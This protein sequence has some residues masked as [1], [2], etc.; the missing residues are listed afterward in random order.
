MKFKHTILALIGF[1][2]YSCT[3]GFDRDN[4]NPNN[5]EIVPTYGIYNNATKNL[6]GI[7][8]RGSFGSARMTL[9]WVQYSASFQYNEESRYEYRRETPESIFNN[10]YQ[11]ANN[12]KKII[13]NVTDPKLKDITATYGDN[14]VQIAA[15]RILIVYTF[16]QLVDMFGDIPY[17]SYGSTNP[18]F[19][20]LD[21]N[22][23]TPKYAKQEDIYA[24]LLIELVEAVDILDNTSETRIFY[25]TQTYIGDNLFKNDVEKLKRFAN[26]LRLRIA[27]RLKN[28]SLSALAA[29]HIDE[30]KADPSLLMQSNDDSV[31]VTYE[32][33]SIN[34]A[35]QYSAFFVDNRTDYTISKTFIDL[36]KGQLANSGLT[37]PDPRLQKVAAPKGVSKSKSLGKEYTETT[38]L[39]Q[40]EG[41]PFGLPNA[42][43]ARQRG[44]NFAN[45]SFY[46]YNL[47]RPDYT[48]YLMEYA[49]V[50]FLLAEANN[51]DQTN[52]EAG[53]KASM[54]KWGVASGDITN[55]VA[56][57]PTANQENVLNQKYIAL[58]MQPYE[59]WSEYRRTG[60]PKFLI[61]PGDPINLITTLTEDS[62]GLTTIFQITAT[63]RSINGNMTDLPAR[64]RYP[65]TEPT[66]NGKN[67]KE[68]VSRLGGDTMQ[69]KL[70]WDN[71]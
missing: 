30:L 33:N 32:N 23:L 36:L 58:F 49:E 61:K 10:Y 20:A 71:N 19:Q 18:D 56:T 24:D 1:S 8:S 17:W 43:G 64:I 53:V 21:V 14:D 3:D 44:D 57:L 45:I 40:Y 54:Q 63:A 39:S 37:T 34:P 26:S 2:L 11:Q 41:M 42:N 29:T 59:A 13:E 27:T 4:T 22:I 48:E 50:E 65:F 52:Y 35:P 60:F 9:P 5:P 7:T 62:I 51:W 67:Y 68:A 55:Y 31:G 16:Q 69:E 70:I 25:P 46:S 15:S 38:D 47:Y 66:L 6:V 12:F 28:S